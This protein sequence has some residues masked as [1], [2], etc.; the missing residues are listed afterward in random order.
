[1]LTTEDAARN[2]MAEGTDDFLDFLTQFSKMY[3]STEAGWL[4]FKKKY[5]ARCKRDL[6][7]FHDSNKDSLVDFPV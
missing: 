5:E 6:L 3:Y 7:K 2:F 4:S 1:M